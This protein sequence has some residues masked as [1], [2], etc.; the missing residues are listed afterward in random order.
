MGLNEENIK[1]SDFKKR[2]RKKAIIFLAVIAVLVIVLPIITFVDFGPKDGTPEDTDKDSW[3]RYYGDQF[4]PEPNFDEVIEEDTEYMKL[5]RLLYYSNG[6]ERFSVDKKSNDLGPCCP[7]F[8]DYFEIL[9]AGDFKNYYSLFTERYATEHGNINFFTK[10]KLIFTKQKVYAIE[11]TLLREA[12]LENGDANGEYVG[13]T[14]YYF[15]VSYKI[16]DNDGT[17]RR[18]ILSDESVPLIFEIIETNGEIKIN[19]I[20]FYKPA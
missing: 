2:S 6:T 18:D 19:D 3:I 5:D 11:V 17:F 16:K 20:S 12:F 10:N 9:K 8:Y 4:F 13:S 14:V 7:L 15:D 1:I